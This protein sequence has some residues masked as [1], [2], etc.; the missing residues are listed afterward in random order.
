MGKVITGAG[1]NEF[2]ESGKHEVIKAHV[3]PKKESKDP[4]AVPPKAS[5]PASD[6]VTAEPLVEADGDMMP[7]ETLEQARAKI[8]KKHRELKAE[9]ALRQKIQSERDENE[10]LAEN[11]FNERRLVEG[12]RDKFKRELE[13]LQSRAAPVKEEPEMK[14]PDENDPKYKDDKGNF[15]WKLFTKDQA[16]FEVAKAKAE[17]KADV[18]REQRAQ[19]EAKVKERVEVAKEKYPDFVEVLQAQE[20]RRDVPNYIMQFMFESEFGADMA[21][22]F[23][24]NREELT[25]ISKLSPIMAIAR[26]G[27]VETKFEKVEKA[28]TVEAPKVEAPAVK[29]ST[30][31]PP[32]TPISA[33][34][35]GNVVTD[36]AKMDFRQLRAYE[37]EKNKR[38]G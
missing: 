13:E 26:L 31:P 38:G 14:E 19:L 3:E 17:A 8:A 28:E 34:S 12:E 18:E 30:A 21:Y 33:S 35:A 25:K 11:Q 16:A 32:I 6:S 22:Y 23:G 5:E 9:K 29:T 37:R 20:D 24:K 4:P 2:I 27:K 36:P 1:L 7:E 15:V 10:K